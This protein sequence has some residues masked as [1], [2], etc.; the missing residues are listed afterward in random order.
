MKFDFQPQY[1]ASAL[2]SKHEWTL[3][4][5]ESVWNGEM[6]TSSTKISPKSTQIVWNAF[7][8]RF[9]HMQPKWT[10]I[11]GVQPEQFVISIWLL[12]GVYLLCNWQ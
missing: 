5:S 6:Q 7:T 11:R 3:S 1:H 10:A 12:R 8:G 9:L 2:F 4:I